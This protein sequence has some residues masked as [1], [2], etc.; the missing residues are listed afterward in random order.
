MPLGERSSP[1]PG[2]V[3]SNMTLSSLFNGL[4]FDGLSSLVD[5]NQTG[6]MLVVLLGWP[7]ATFTSKVAQ[8]DDRAMVTRQIDGG[9]ETPELELPTVITT[10]RRLNEPHY[11]T[12]PNILKANNKL[13]ETV[14]PEGLGVDVSRRLTMRNVG[15]SPD[16]NDGVRVPDMA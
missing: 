2:A 15:E 12:L 7:Q 11:A 6:Q 8:V 14:R 4:G 9:L 1:K 5:A 13:V 10:D 3:F 16:R